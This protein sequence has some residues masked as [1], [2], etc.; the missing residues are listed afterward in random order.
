LF[1]EATYEPIKK[2][3]EDS[4]VNWLLQPKD[5]SVRYLTLTDILN[6]PKDSSEVEEARRRIPFGPRVSVLLDGQ[7]SDGGFGVH[8][9]Q[10]WTGA[11]WRLISLVELGYLKGTARR[12]R[13]PIWYSSGCLA[14]LTF[15]MFHKSTGFIED[16]LLKKETHSPSA[17]VWEP[18]KTIA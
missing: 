2:E 16:A 13:Q 15:G 12:L 18:P 17:A 8:P 14:T 5:P 4:T 6:M 10:K 11:H 3:T 1:K 7:E 9:Y